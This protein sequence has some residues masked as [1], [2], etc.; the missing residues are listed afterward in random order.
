MRSAHF[1]IPLAVLTLGVFACLPDETVSTNAA[2]SLFDAS[3][4]LFTIRST[5]DFTIGDSEGSELHL[6]RGA[7]F[8][9]DRVAIANSGYH[10]IQLADK[11][12][13]ILARQGRKGFGPGEYQNIQSVHVQGDRLVVW[14][15]GLQRVNYL[16]AKLGF[17]DS[18]TIRIDEFG[19]VRL[20]GVSDS[21]G[22][23]ED[24]PRGFPGTGRVGPIEQRLDVKYEL[25]DL[26]TGTTLYATSRAGSE[27]WMRRGERGEMHGG[28][29]ISFGRDAV[30]SVPSFG[31]VIGQT[32][33]IA[34]ALFES[35]GDSILLV[36]QEPKRSVESGWGDWVR[37]TLRQNAL[38]LR[39]RL[40]PRSEFLSRAETFRLALLEDLPERQTL[41]SF[42][43]LLGGSDGLLWIRGYPEP[44][45]THVV[46]VGV[47]E[48][49]RPQRRLRLPLG[50]ALVAVGEDALLLSEYTETGEYLLHKHSLVVAG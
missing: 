39:R 21:I 35:N 3:V 40:G 49:M 23:F 38:T 14:D 50:F 4:E 33:S 28:L 26:G 24:R 45:S 47:N 36:H 1:L 15:E 16:D 6:F 34:L 25:V 32:D 37:D 42:S 19:G 7:V 8:F 9:G 44:R 18:Q 17:I 27:Q 12:G 29:P 41:P 2:P 46:W 48:A 13:A 10:E 22:L 20:L 31:P 30:A 11:E 43:A 5:P